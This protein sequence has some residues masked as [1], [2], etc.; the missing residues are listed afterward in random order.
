MVEIILPPPFVSVIIPIFNEEN[1]LAD[2][3]H[4]IFEN[5]YPKDRFEVILVDGGSTDGSK[6]ILKAFLEKYQN[7]SL[8]DN[9]KKFVAS[10]LNLGAKAARG[11]FLLR[12]DA[13]AIYDEYY[14]SKSVEV[15]IEN[16]AAS[17]GGHRRAIGV[18]KIGK[19]IAAT[20]SS[21]VGAGN[22]RYQQTSKSG[23]ADTVFCGIWRKKDFNKIGG[24]DESWKVNQDSE[25]NNRLK[26][27]VGGLYHSDQ[28]KCNYFVRESLSDLVVQYFRYGFWRAK[29][30]LRHIDQISMRQLIPATLV[31]S[32]IVGILLVPFSKLPISVLLSVYLVVLVVAALKIP[33]KDVVVKLL[34]PICALIIHISWGIGYVVGIPIHFVKNIFAQ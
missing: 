1:Y 19:A 18:S 3:L 26:K 32:L 17:A 24:F 33:T 10:S 2:C 22:A 13:H 11:E 34:I 16:N 6:E 31:L 30:A 27:L 4:S 21:P 25:F 9:P 7:L 14:I 28:I 5:S 23:W 20:I 12:M 15:L 8:L 29:T